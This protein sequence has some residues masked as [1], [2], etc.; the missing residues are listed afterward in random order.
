MKTRVCPP[1]PL[2]DRLLMFRPWT[3]KLCLGSNQCFVGNSL[4]KK[5]KSE[6][7]ACIHSQ[8]G[9]ILT[10]DEVSF[11]SSM[12]CLTMS[13]LRFTLYELNLAGHTWLCVLFPPCCPQGKQLLL[14]VQATSGVVGYFPKNVHFV[15]VIYDPDMLV[16]LGNF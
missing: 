3:S 12:F 5:K 9:A 10:A 4:A 2:T 13:D 14:D 6:K 11:T 7:D 15:F 16:S 8:V 1:P